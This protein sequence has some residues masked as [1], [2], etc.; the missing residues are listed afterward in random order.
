M[1]WSQ[2]KLGDCIT[3]NIPSANL[4][5]QKCVV[6]GRTLNVGRNTVTLIFRTEDDAKHAWALGVTGTVGAPPT[7]A[8]PPGTGDGALTT[9]DVTQL[10]YNSSYI[11]TPPSVAAAGTVSIPTHTRRY[12]DKDVTVTGATGVIHGGTTGQTVAIYYDQADR[13]GGA[14]TYHTIVTSGGPSPDALA[15]VTNP[16]RHFVGYG[17]VPASGT[18]GGG[19]VGGGGYGGGGGGWGEP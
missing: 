5:S 12:A 17:V 4:N 2:Y 11:G 15:S 8:Q 18:A 16:Y 14:V 9:T 13:S 7:V 6:I 3:L 1:L 19:S 10:I